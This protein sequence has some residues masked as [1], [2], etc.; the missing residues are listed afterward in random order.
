MTTKIENAGMT[1]PKPPA[2]TGPHIS[3]SVRAALKEQ[4]P[5]IARHVRQV[6]DTK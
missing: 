3:E 6:A 2:P 5:E 1:A 4:D